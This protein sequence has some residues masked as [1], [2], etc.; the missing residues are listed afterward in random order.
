MLTRHGAPSTPLPTGRPATPTQ[1]AL[2]RRPRAV[3][4]ASTVSFVS[5]AAVG[6]VGHRPWRRRQSSQRHAEGRC[7][8]VVS[9][10]S[11]GL[12]VVATEPLLAGQLV[13]E[14]APALRWS[15]AEDEVE[16]K[17]C[18]EE[19]PV[20]QQQELWQLEDAFSVGAKTLSGIAFTNSFQAGE[21]LNPQDLDLDDERVLYLE[22]SRFNHSC[23]PNCEVSWDDREGLLQIYAGRDV[24][25][26]EDL[27]LYYQ[28]VRMPRLS[29]Q[30]KL[31]SLGFTCACRACRAADRRSD[32]RRQRMQ[33][34]LGEMEEVEEE[35]G[36][37]K[38]QELLDLY[39]EE[40]LTVLHYRKAAAFKAYAMS[41]ALGNVA[42]AAKWAEMAAEYSLQCHGPL[43]PQTK[44]LS[45]HARRAADLN[46]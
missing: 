15:G 9:T 39:D 14:E 41:T 2:F 34:L 43:H 4:R 3:P 36:V 22:I 27:C 1:V 42:D 38:V 5:A 24:A 23:L 19:L 11:Q 35:E 16:L 37:A 46:G 7:Y 8:Q 6:C 33:Q 44:V 20:E 12:G 30:E 21:P 17:E 45:R 26:G 13:T 31:K 25:L 29:R 10:E 18:F 32:Q 28:D 40:G